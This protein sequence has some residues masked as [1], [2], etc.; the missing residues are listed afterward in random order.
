MRKAA[1][2][3]FAISMLV[4]VGV[5]AAAPAG[6][7]GTP[8]CKTLKGTQTYT[9]SLPKIGNST[10]VNS[11]TLANAT[12]GG[13]VGGGV[14]SGKSVSKGTYVGNC[15]TLLGA[16]V[17]T[18]TKGTAVITWSDKKTSTV[19]TTLKSLGKATA[20]GTPLQLSS[21]VT[22][23]EFLGLKTTV[24]IVAKAPAG[25]CT[26]MNLS[27]FDFQNSGPFTKG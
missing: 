10:K 11:K 15:T 12:L 5:L 9:P 16:K 19:A 27:K 2:L 20:K 14:T 18:V 26:S 22:K 24:K 4:P 8:T 1:G 3:L 6:A 21:T 17:G 13:C 7:A 25:S 23:G